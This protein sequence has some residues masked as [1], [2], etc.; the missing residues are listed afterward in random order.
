[1]VETRSGRRFAVLFF[2]AAF[3]VFFLGR[4]LEPIDHVG[5][6]MAAPFASAIST[7]SNA[8]GDTIAGVFVGPRL[9]DE[10]YRLKKEI[11]ALLRSNVLLQEARHENLLL[12]RI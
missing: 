8:V 3:L 5:L 11:G 1:M 7:A 10:N 2:V 6:S 9:R 4:W 12:R